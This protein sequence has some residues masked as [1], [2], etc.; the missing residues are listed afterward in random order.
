MY[1]FLCFPD[2]SERTALFCYCTSEPIMSVTLA[3]AI[4]SLL[5]AAV[6]FHSHKDNVQW[7]LSRKKGALWQ[8][9]H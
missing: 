5:P 2:A 4:I 9:K 1:K 8:G 3:V 6:S 7:H